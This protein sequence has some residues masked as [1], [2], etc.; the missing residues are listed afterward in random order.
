MGWLEALGQE[1][2]WYPSLLNTSQIPY[3]KY[4]LPCWFREGIP[5]EFLRI[6]ISGR[7]FSFHV[8]K[9]KKIS[10]VTPSCGNWI[11]QTHS[12]KTYFIFCTAEVKRWFYLSSC[13]LLHIKPLA[14]REKLTISYFSLSGLAAGVY[15]ARTDLL[16]PTST[17]WG[18]LLATLAISPLTVEAPEVPSP[19]ATAA[20]GVCRSIRAFTPKNS[21]WQ[22]SRGQDDAFS[23]PIWGILAVVKV[24]EDE[25]VYISRPL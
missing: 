13:F 10:T 9:L 18:K 1:I 14:S 11:I 21:S 8:G 2:F 7:P 12:K 24:D 20:L 4:T 3:S 16:R 15:P 22:Y 23:G 19:A 17:T 6:T 5:I 25:S